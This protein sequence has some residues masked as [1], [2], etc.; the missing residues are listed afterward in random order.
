[1][2]YN[3]GASAIYAWR[4]DVHFLVEWVGYWNQFGEP[5]VSRRYEFASLISPGARKAFDFANDSQLV[6]G[7]AVPM[8]VTAS[9][10]DASV[11]LYVSFE[12]FLAKSR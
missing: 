3:L 5:G 9:G 4:R 11:F 2:H 12:H 7:L 6:L 1:M 8:K 10:P